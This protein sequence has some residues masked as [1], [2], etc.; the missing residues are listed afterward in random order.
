MTYFED[1]D[2]A[3]FVYTIE[4]HPSTIGNSSLIFTYLLNHFLIITLFR[5]YLLDCLQNNQ[6]DLFS[7]KNIFWLEGK[8]ENHRELIKA[9]IGLTLCGLSYH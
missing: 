5:K 7:V 3:S 6:A 4:R 1:P 8:L 2:L 9:L